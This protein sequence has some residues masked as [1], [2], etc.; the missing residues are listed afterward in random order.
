MDNERPAIQILVDA[1][2]QYADG[3]GTKLCREEADAQRAIRRCLGD[4]HGGIAAVGPG[5]AQ[6]GLP[7]SRCAAAQRGSIQFFDVRQK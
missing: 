7:I 4:G 6:G 5:T 2:R 3:M 1:H